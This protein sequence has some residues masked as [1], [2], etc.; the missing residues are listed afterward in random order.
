MAVR[1]SGNFGTYFFVGFIGML[2]GSVIGRTLVNLLRSRVIT[3]IIYLYG[4]ANN[5]KIVAGYVFNFN[6][7]AIIG[8]VL[9]IYIYRRI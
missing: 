8:I 5:F 1:R 3:D 6:L 2:I 4:F 7:I 9:A